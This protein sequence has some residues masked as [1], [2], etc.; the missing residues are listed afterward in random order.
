MLVGAT[1]QAR[2]PVR[3]W[4][5]P[6]VRSPSGSYYRRANWLDLTPSLPAT[7]GRAQFALSHVSAYRVDLG[8]GALEDEITLLGSATVELW[9]SRDDGAD[10]DGDGDTDCDDE[11]CA[12]SPSCR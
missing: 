10:N 5:G 11:T 8:A 6:S 2:T 7:P 12:A 9:S 3:S 4:I 1:V